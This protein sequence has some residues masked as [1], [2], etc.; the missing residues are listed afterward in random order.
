MSCSL[1]GAWGRTIK[2]SIRFQLMG[3]VLACVLPIWAAAGFLTYDAYR[4]KLALVERRMEET[5]G[6]LMSLVDRELE[7]VRAAL[8][9]LATSPSLTAGDFAAFDAQAHSLLRNY[10]P[11]TNIMVA[12]AKGQQLVNTFLP[13]G[14]TLPHRWDTASVSHVFKTGQPVLSNLFFGLLSGEPYIGWDVPVMKDGRVVLDLA[15]VLPTGRL[16]DI[17]KQYGLPDPWIATLWDPVGMMVARTRNLEAHVG[18]KV[19]PGVAAILQGKGSGMLEQANLDGVPAL[20]TV[21]KSSET[22]FA[23]V[24]NVSHDALTAELR[25]WLIWTVAGGVTVS[26]LGLA[27]ALVIARRIVWAIQSLV[28]PAVALGEGHAVEI[29]PQGLSEVDEVAAALHTGA[30]LLARRDQERQQANAELAEINGRL[31]RSNADLESFAY[32]AS[33]DLRQPLRMVSSYVSLLERRYADQ[34]D[35]EAREFI[36]FARDGA[37]RMDHLIIDLLEY[38]RIGRVERAMAPVSLAEVVAEARLNLSLAI[39][40]N[41]ATIDIPA[42]LPTLPGCREELVRLFQNLFSNALKY[43]APE[44]A[45]VISVTLGEGVVEAGAAW[46]LTVCDNGIG[47]APEHFERIFGIFQRLH[48]DSRYEGTGIGLAVCKKIAEHHGGH[49]TVSSQLGEGTCFAVSLLK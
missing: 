23:I 33:H 9:A 20:L 17:L 10:P 40:E 4:Y 42:D 12:D 2:T 25:Q 28:K 22:G 29:A 31:A 26:L 43:H 37:K 39:E 14:G 19:S 11:G 7:G 27:L 3:L 36:G 6:A 44:R 18:K 49:I 41:R 46:V 47:I 5:T 24:L 8:E 32:V 45:P 38:S 1:H 16:A 13:Y 48:S 30:A 15:V 34:L 21:K 35:D